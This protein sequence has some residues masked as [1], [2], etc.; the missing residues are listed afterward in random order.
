[1]PQRAELRRWGWEGGELDLES[2]I[3][4]LLVTRRLQGNSTWSNLAPFGKEQNDENCKRE[5]QVE[6]QN[7]NR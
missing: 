6:Y 2:N 1:M 4:W 7:M 3:S 5:K